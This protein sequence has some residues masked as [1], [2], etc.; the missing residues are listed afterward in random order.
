MN[1]RASSVGGSTCISKNSK[2]GRKLPE[3][4]AHLT[5][6]F[7]ERYRFWKR[8]SGLECWR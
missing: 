4:Y 1:V 5:V 6:K 3:R 8:M 7:V 2:A